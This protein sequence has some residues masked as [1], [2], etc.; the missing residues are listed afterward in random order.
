VTRSKNDVGYRQEDKREIRTQLA[1]EP[2]GRGRLAEW[3]LV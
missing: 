1:G 2:P 3:G